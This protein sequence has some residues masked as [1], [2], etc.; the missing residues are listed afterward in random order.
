MPLLSNNATSIQA[1]IIPVAVAFSAKP[2]D[3]LL[4]VKGVCIG[5]DG[6]AT[7]DTSGGG[8]PGPSYIPPRPKRKR[9]QPRYSRQKGSLSANPIRVISAVHHSA[10][11]LTTGNI[12]DIICPNPDDPE[13]SVLRASIQNLKN[14]RILSPVPED[15][16]MRNPHYQLTTK[17]AKIAN[18]L[19]QPEPKTGT[20]D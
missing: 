11:P 8:I 19:N 7:P 4:I 16:G 3:N 12:L 15:R 1:I 6:H 10:Q 18:E 9:K 2:G 13:R 14:K 20:E 5:L 17:G